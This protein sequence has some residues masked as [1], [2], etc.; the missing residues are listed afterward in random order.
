MHC[1]VLFV[2]LS[3]L[4]LYCIGRADTILAC[5]H[6][7][8]FWVAFV[9]YKSLADISATSA[10]QECLYVCC[11]FTSHIV[12]PARRRPRHVNMSMIFVTPFFVLCLFTGT[13]D[14]SSDGADRSSSDISR[15]KA[16]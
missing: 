6:L 10:Y 5:Q 15:S 11:M 1:F 3:A 9:C 4:R 12:P 14:R 8:R 7:W 2:L 16:D 13:Q